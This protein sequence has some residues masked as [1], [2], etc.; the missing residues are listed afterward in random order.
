MLEE[1]LALLKSYCFVSI[2]ISGT[3]FEMHRLIQFAAKLWMD[4][5]GEMPQWRR[6]FLQILRE[7][8]PYADDAQPSL[9]TR[10]ELLYPHA[11]VASLDEP[12]SQ[13]SQ[14]PPPPSWHPRPI[15]GAK[16]GPI[17]EDLLGDFG[18]GM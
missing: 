15:R 11:V 1:D 8:F 16:I 9:W 18:E 6:Q 5:Q 17:T 14:Y 4:A 10:C 13:C 2:H 3:S 12:D 7:E